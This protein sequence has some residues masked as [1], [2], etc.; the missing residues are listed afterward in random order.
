[1][2]NNNNCKLNAHFIISEQ[3]HHTTKVVLVKLVK[4]IC[5]ALFETT[6]A[7]QLTKT[8]MINN[9]QIAGLRKYIKKMRVN[10]ELK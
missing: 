5:K 1:M 3:E 2:V 9:F 7:I 10:Y 6:L 4:F 8:K